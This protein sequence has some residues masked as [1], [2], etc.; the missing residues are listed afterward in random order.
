M[1][2][3]CITM[4]ESNQLKSAENDEVYLEFKV[5]PLSF[6]ASALDVVAIISPPKMVNVPI[7][8]DVMASCFNYHNETVTVLSMHNKFGLPFTREIDRTHIILVRIDNDLKGF[9]VDQAIDI[10]PPSVFG[11]SE[12]YYPCEGK[13]YS[14]FLTRNDEIILETTFKRLY[15]CDKSSLHWIAEMGSKEGDVSDNKDDTE[16]AVDVGGLNKI[17]NTENETG[18]VEIN[19]AE[20]IAES[21]QVEAHQNNHSAENIK[22]TEINKTS[23]IE[24]EQV[25]RK[26]EFTGVGQ[27]IVDKK[28][29]I[30]TPDIL[31]NKDSSSQSQNITEVRNRGA[32]REQHT[33]QPHTYTRNVIDEDEIKNQNSN[34]NYVTVAS[35]VLMILVVVLGGVYLLDIKN[36]ATTQ[37]VDE[38][39]RSSSGYEESE[40]TVYKNDKKMVVSEENIAL[41]D[42][43]SSGDA[44]LNAIEE[45]NEIV[46]GSST[47][48]VFELHINEKESSNYGITRFEPVKDLSEIKKTGNA[49]I[50]T[51]IVIKGDTLWHITRRYLDDPH[52][53]PELAEASHIKNPHRIYPGDVIKIIVSNSGTTN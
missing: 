43:P 48:R 49:K 53:Y 30:K 33:P 21:V 22:N 1:H 26:P 18:Q 14:N 31:I 19:E 36:S 13:A 52:R 2:A 38:S 27:N 34:F 11:T 47:A 17:E 45:K 6:C 8:L 32:L 12:D 23:N 24:I 44:S 10:M 37:N 25:K 9:W 29:E 42:S 15:L 4:D 35:V 20:Q 5:G 16:N 7:N 51:H 3:K 41:H 50:Y 46:A 28:N 40:P 39:I